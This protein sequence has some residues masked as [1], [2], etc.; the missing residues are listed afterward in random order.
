[1]SRK[2]I[3]I[4]YD[5]FGIRMAHVVNV[6]RWP[7]GLSL[8]SDSLLQHSLR[9]FFAE[10]RQPRDGRCMIGPILN[11]LYRFYPNRSTLEPG[12][13]VQLSFVVSRRMAFAT[14][15]HFF[16]KISAPFN[17]TFVVRFVGL[18]HTTSQ[19]QAT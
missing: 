2:R 18:D 12:L 14:F 8:R 6:H 10:P 9:L 16:Y 7:Q 5:R 17:L 13:L 15:G 4:S 1:M 19:E 11:W 3:Q